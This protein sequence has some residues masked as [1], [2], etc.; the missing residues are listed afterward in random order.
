MREQCGGAFICLFF[1]N[2]FQC[3][4]F[5]KSFFSYCFMSP[6]AVWDKLQDDHHVPS[7]L[8]RSTICCFIYALYLLQDF[9]GLINKASGKVSGNFGH[10]RECSSASSCVGKASR[11][12]AQTCAL[13]LVFEASKG[14]T[15]AETAAG[16]CL[17]GRFPAGL[18][19]SH[20]S[21]YF[22]RPP[23]FPFF[24]PP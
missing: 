8:K 20:P 3:P 10:Q 5:E 1:L 14:E 6:L 18:F 23:P 4:A 11:V 2:I 12:L 13:R 9:Q 16:L 17:W 24:I 15:E 21:I 19:S 7:Y 22:T